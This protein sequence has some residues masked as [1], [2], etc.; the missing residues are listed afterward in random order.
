MEGKKVLDEKE[1]EERKR[2]KGKERR[3]EKRRKKKGNERRGQCIS[4]KRG[5]T[6]RRPLSILARGLSELF[7]SSLNSFMR[8]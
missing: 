7:L 2:I 1:G 3:G 8:S 5:S 4:D 6:Y